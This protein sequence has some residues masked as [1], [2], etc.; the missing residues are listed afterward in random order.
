MLKTRYDSYVAVEK[1]SDGRR[2]EDRMLNHET[3]GARRKGARR[4]GKNSKL[5]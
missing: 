3:K 1:K 2:K 4:K 5:R